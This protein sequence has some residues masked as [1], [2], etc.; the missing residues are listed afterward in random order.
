MAADLKGCGCGRKP[1]A[2]MVVLVDLV[3]AAGGKGLARVDDKVKADLVDVFETTPGVLR[4]TF[5]VRDACNKADLREV[6][7]I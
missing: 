4:S 5:M 1:G 3:V 7:E 6:P 2:A